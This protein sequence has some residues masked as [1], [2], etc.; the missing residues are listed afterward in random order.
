MAGDILRSDGVRG[1]YRGLPG[2]WIK[3]IP[4]S[5]IYFGSYEASKSLMRHF[6]QTD[7]LRKYQMYFVFKH[8]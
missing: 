4:G 8:P 1:L 2:I 3:E 5:F 7:H 6:A